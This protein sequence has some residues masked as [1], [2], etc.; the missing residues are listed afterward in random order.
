MILSLSL[1]LSLPLPL[2]P[3]PPSLPQ[4]P[5]LLSIQAIQDLGATRIGHGY[6]ALDDPAVYQLAI[7]RNIHFEVRA[8]P[9]TNS[10][11][12]LTKVIHVRLAAGSTILME[13]ISTCM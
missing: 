10:T 11:L 1:S 2:P 12:Y 9:N 4:L 5:V 6:H 8:N 7:Q 3:S 13:Y